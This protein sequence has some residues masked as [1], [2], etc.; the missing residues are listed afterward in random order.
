MLFGIPAVHLLA[1]QLAIAGVLAAMGQGI[2]PLAVA[3]LLALIVFLLTAVRLQRKWLYQYL[4]ARISYTMRNKIAQPAPYVDP[5]SALLDFLAPA[6]LVTSVEVDGQGVGV[7][8]HAAGVTALLELGPMDA[9]LVSEATTRLPNPATLLPP[10]DPNSPPLT[11][12]LLIQAS[13]APALTVG[14]GAAATSYRQLTEGLI[15]ASRR[16]WIAIRLGRE[17]TT[18]SDADLRQ[19]LGSAARRLGR[20]LHQDQVLA[21]TLDREEVLA[22]VGLLAHLPPGSHP[23]RGSAAVGSVGVASVSAASPGPIGYETW[24]AWWSGE[25]A[26]TTLSLHKWPDPRTEAGKHVL[27]T[28]LAAPG[29]ATTVSLAARRVDV[30]P[31]DLPGGDAEPELVAVEMGIRLAAPTPALLG[32]AVSALTSSLKASGAGVDRLGGSQ[33]A[34]LAATLPFGGFLK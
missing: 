11:L 16:A 29:M 19:A 28:A 27:T 7:V 1:W 30:R 4:A 5:R 34:G 9:G 23:V 20:R 10:A 18:H 22:A 32:G 26:Q 12:Q 13:P 25:T 8:E 24:G 33:A 17:G 6:T 21:R 31:A 2:V 15:P 14:G 3:G